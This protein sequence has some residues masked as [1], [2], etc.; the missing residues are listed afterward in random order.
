MVFNFEFDKLKNEL[1]KAKPKRVFV[2][3]P[4]GI[5]SRAFE[6]SKMIEELGIEV[7]FSGDTCWGGCSVSSDEARSVGADLIIH[8]GHAEFMKVD[9][10]IIY[11]EIKDEIDLSPLLK[12]SLEKLK[13]FSN[14]GIIY[15]IQHRHDL[16]MIK[17]FYEENGKKIFV[18]KGLGHAAYSG[19]V[20]G[21]EFSGLKLIKNEIDA[22]VVIGNNF[23][24]M[25]AS[26][27]IDKPVFLIDVYNND[28][29]DMSNI[30]D[31]II[32]QRI[33]SI[34]KFKSFKKIGIIVEAKKGQ[35]FGSAELI[36]KKLEEAGFETVILIM[37]EV[38]QDKLTNF[39]NIEGFV[40][41]ACPRIAIDDFGKYNKPLITFKEAMVVAGVES[42]EEM[43]G[44]GVV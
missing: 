36:K 20:V 1:E 11:M 31:K 26:L 34:E 18:P 42:F 2:Q 6:I 39:N 23:H 17:K 40:E 28:I 25:G 5:K 27:A 13:D 3:L 38:T 30:R 8:F 24:S 41:L 14:L 32:R 43:L 35:K 4:E 29:V 16:E 10:P 44:R 19:H 9:F 33:L 37:N 7:V 15:S 21:C 22:V 12:K